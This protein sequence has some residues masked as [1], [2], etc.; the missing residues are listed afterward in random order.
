MLETY[1]SFDTKKREATKNKLEQEFN[2]LL[3]NAFSGKTIESVRNR[4]KVK[5][6]KSGADM[7]APPP[8]QKK[9]KQVKW[10]SKIDFDG[11]KSSNGFKDIDSTRK[12]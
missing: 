12:K 10:H 3:Y 11:V 9:N 2:K 6:P 1:I 7:Q 8:T 4:V 5:I